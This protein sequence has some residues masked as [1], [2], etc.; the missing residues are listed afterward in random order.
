MLL[1][2]AVMVGIQVTEADRTAM[3]ATAAAA[4]AAVGRLQG[5]L[6]ATVQAQATAMAGVVQQ[7]H[8]LQERRSRE[9]AQVAQELQGLRREVGAAKGALIA[10]LGEGAKAAGGAWETSV[11]GHKR[12]AGA[13]SAAAGAAVGAMGSALEGV[14][15]SLDE[16]SVRL[17]ALA[18][19]QRAAAEGALAH[20]RAS[21]R[22]AREGVSSMATATSRLQ[23]ASTN[24]AG[25][26]AST[27]GA[28]QSE[29]EATTA[30]RQ[31]ALMQQ[32]G[33]LLGSFVDERRAEVAGMVTG[34]HAQ[35]QTLIRTAVH[36]ACPLCVL[37][38][39]CQCS[40]HGRQGVTLACVPCRWR[41]GGQPW[42]SRRLLWR[43]QPAAASA[44]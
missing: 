31:A 17:A 16:Q 3:R 9:V 28:F 11:A 18:Q 29:F 44:S 43:R 23:Q 2:A 5:E 19:Q 22:R 7:A 12:L 33:Q 15:A 34:L 8:A 4:V 13:A 32:I 27:L 24:A 37:H 41:K 10:R 38:A 40:W 35:V 21:L 20:L 14:V 26:A 6:G 25:A 39:V 42:S 1:T 36:H 30:S